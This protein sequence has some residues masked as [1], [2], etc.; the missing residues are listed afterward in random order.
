MSLSR[1]T[2]ILLFLLVASLVLSVAASVFYL[3]QGDALKHSL[4]NRESLGRLEALL[5]EKGGSFDDFAARIDKLFWGRVVIGIPL[6]LLFYFGLFLIVKQQF[7]LLSISKQE[8]LLTSSARRGGLLPATAI[9]VVVTL[10]FYYPILSRLSTHLIGPA[11]DNMQFFW[12]FWWGY[13][14]VIHGQGSL[15]ATK[16]MYYPE[17][18]SL[19]YHSLSL[20]NVFFSFAL[21]SFLDP[22]AT[23]NILVMHS[24]LLSGIGAFLLIRYLTGRPYLAILGGFVYAFSPSHFAHSLHHINIASIQFLPFFL[25]YFIRA[26]RERRNFDL[27]LAILFFVLNALCSW[28]YLIF[29][30]Y[31]LLFAYIYLAIRRRQ[32]WLRDVAGRIA[33]VTIA[34]LAL[35]SPWLGRMV[36]LGLKQTGITAIGHSWLVGDLLGLVTPTEHQLAGALP[37]VKEINASYTG[38]PW[39]ATVYLGLVVLAI[40]IYSYRSIYKAGAR[41]LLGA[42]LFLVFTFGSHIHVL[43]QTVPVILPYRVLAFVPFLS[44]IRAPGRNIVFVYL[45]LA[46]ILVLA[47]RHFLTNAR[48]KRVG[49]TIVAML[50]LLVFADYFSVCR[51]YVRVEVPACYEIIKQDTDEFGIL[52]LPSGY[53]QVNRYMLYQTYHHLPMVQGWAS[54]KTDESLIDHLEF[55]DLARQR[56]QLTSNRVK[57]IVVH[58]ALMTPG[59]PPHADEY[60]DWYTPVLDDSECIVYRVY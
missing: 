33:V 14:V 43:G 41:Y 42:L 1:S 29:A 28:N 5:P 44:N 32:V 53:E 58:K 18:A 40:V 12:G 3:I 27:I 47:L 49:V 51:E 52:D 30:G 19:L 10:L 35:M 7:R 50:S 57:Y 23:Y 16:V 55:S 31:F 21:R 17:G 60:D 13:E 48:S 37:L 45:F 20:Y 36:H 9:F 56:E 6:T 4:Y 38:N 8:P 15:L 39:E 2:R 34:G 22:I 25:L 54:R 11:E 26:V 59:N 46:V 24:F